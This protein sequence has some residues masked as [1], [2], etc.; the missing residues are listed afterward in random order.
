MIT[1]QIASI[2]WFNVNCV[3]HSVV[4]HDLTDHEYDSIRFD[5]IFLGMYHNMS[6]KTHTDSTAYCCENQ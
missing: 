6:N 5:D 3:C 2:G 4:L 1:F